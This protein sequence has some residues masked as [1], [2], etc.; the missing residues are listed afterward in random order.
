MWTWAEQR[1]KKKKRGW[2]KFLH[3]AYQTQR[4][5]SEVLCTYKGPINQP[6]E[7]FKH[8]CRQSY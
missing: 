5:T 8:P 2:Q 6:A 1:K 7:L 3:T 4:Q